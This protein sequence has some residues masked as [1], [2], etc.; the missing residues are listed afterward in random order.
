V[1][2]FDTPDLAINKAGVVVR[3]RRVQGRGNDSVVKLRPVV[4]DELPP[5]VRLSP[6]FG[7]EVDALPGGYVCS[8]SMKHAM[9]TR[10]VKEAVTGTLPL[11]K[12]FS[13][14]QRALYRA[15]AP[16]DSSWTISRSL[17]R[18]WCSR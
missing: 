17:A 3:G 11:S 14:E 5:D 15:Y 13:K 16:K 8:G 4:P 1:Y 12:L 2:F 7:V 10:E 18:C 9:G 6:N